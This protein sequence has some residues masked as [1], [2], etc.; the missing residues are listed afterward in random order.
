MYILEDVL[1]L[2]EFHVDLDIDEKKVTPACD[3][4]REEK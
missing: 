3:V 4:C 1:A 2:P